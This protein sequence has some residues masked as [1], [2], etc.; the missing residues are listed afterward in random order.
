M[1]VFMSGSPHAKCVV[2]GSCLSVEPVSDGCSRTRAI[3]KQRRTA[4]QS[5]KNDRGLQQTA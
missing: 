1:S 3:M 2:P 4:G 5:A